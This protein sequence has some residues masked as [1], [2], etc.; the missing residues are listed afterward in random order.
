MKVILVDIYCIRLTYATLTDAL[1]HC[2]TG[3]GE[4]LCSYTHALLLLGNMFGLIYYIFKNFFYMN[5]VP[6]LNRKA[7]QFEAHSTPDLG[8][9]P[10]KLTI[11]FFPFF[12]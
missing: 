9:L 1:I 7:L 8:F 4:I 11:F 5:I 12:Q 2:M 6:I 10:W 3:Y